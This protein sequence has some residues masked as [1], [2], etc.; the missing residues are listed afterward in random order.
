VQFYFS[1]QAHTGKLNVWYDGIFIGELQTSIKEKQDID[2]T[3]Y[4]QDKTLRMPSGERYSLLYTPIVRI[5]NTGI[6]SLN[7][8]SSREEAAQSLL[9]HHRKLHGNDCRE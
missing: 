6:S 4:R 7:Y 3:K 5:G 9:D 2:W 1:K 8:C